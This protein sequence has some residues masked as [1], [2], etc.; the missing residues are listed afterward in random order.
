MNHTPHFASNFTYTTHTTHKPYKN[1]N[2]RIM[3][4]D[5]ALPGS[6]GSSDNAAA[7]AGRSMH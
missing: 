6:S 5:A 2:T 3:V 7:T 1:A 4:F